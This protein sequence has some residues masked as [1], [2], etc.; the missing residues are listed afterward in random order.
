MGSLTFRSLDRR[1]VLVLAG[2]STASGLAGCLGGSDPGTSTET[3]TSSEGVPAA[4][5]TATNL[6]GDRRKPEDLVAKSDLSYQPD[7]KNGQQ[8]SDCTYYIPD[9]DGDGL[10]ACSI[11]EGTIEPAGWCTSYVAHEETTN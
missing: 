3:E 10:G 7:P 4:Y 5:R 6:N 9:K 8:C 2:S 1:T 11:V